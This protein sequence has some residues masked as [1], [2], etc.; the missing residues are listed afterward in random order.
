MRAAVVRFGRRVVLNGCDLDFC[1]A[2]STAVVGPS[3]SGKTTLL[4]IIGGLHS[5]TSGSVRLIDGDNIEHQL[6]SQIAWVLQT[7][8]ALG[9]RSL[10]ANVLLGSLLSCASDSDRQ[11]AATRTIELM[12]LT[13]L[14]EKPVRHLSGGETQRVAI[15]R[16]VVANRLFI[17]A[18][19]PTG[20]LDSRTTEQVLDTLF[21]APK[22][23]LI[24]AT[25]DPRV[26]DRCDRVVNMNDI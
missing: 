5:P 25:H 13:S 20:Q 8:N 16:A 12:G 18:D 2:G 9:R 3:G 6:R 26:W 23:A 10:L 7:T 1:S 24:V 19:E 11:E 17:L 4:S 14:R 22:Q 21:S 15:A